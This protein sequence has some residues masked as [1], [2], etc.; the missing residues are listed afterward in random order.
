MEPGA[1]QLLDRRAPLPAVPVPE[2]VLPGPLGWSSMAELPDAVPVVD[3]PDPAIYGA[4]AFYPAEIVQPGPVQWQ[5]GR[6]LLPLRVFPFRYNPVAGKLSYYPDVR[7][8]VRV[9][10]GPKPAAEDAYQLQPGI[11]EPWAVN[12]PPPHRRWRRHAHPHR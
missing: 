3:R 8:T 11:S 10:P 4:D 9:E 12:P 7:I 2:P 5:R 6:R 1:T